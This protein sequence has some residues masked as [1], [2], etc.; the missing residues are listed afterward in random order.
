VNRVNPVVCLEKQLKE[1]REKRSPEGR[2]QGWYAA[3]L[4]AQSMTPADGLASVLGHFP[5]F[6]FT[7]SCRCLITEFKIST[8]FS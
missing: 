6:W 1:K 2:Q 7:S 4:V 5:L 3:T 8:A